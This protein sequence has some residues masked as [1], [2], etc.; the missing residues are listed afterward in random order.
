MAT[1]PNTSAHS[2]TSTAIL[3]NQSSAPPNH[4]AFVPKPLRVR[5]PLISSASLLRV[6]EILAITASFV[7]ATV[8]LI[9]SIRSTQKAAALA[10]QAN[11]I[12]SIA[13]NEAAEANDLTLAALCQADRTVRTRRRSSLANPIL[14]EILVSPAL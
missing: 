2:P 10:K 14:T 9:E 4:A 12:A 7:I 13:A 6:F 5:P 8:S 3:Q 11:T 1:S